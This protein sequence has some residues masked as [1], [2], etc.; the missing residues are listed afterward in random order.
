MLESGLLDSKLSN[1]TAVAS[2]RTPQGTATPQMA[3]EPDFPLTSDPFG[4]TIVFRYIG[5][6]HLWLWLGFTGWEGFEPRNPKEHCSAESHCI[7]GG[8]R[9]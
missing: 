1:R 3:K 7:L 4:C 8:R 2:Y 9:W 6:L 5:A